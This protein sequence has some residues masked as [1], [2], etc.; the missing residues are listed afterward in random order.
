MSGP[1][2]G[3]YMP[4]CNA[5]SLEGRGPAPYPRLGNLI[6]LFNF[7]VSLKDEPPN[8]IRFAHYSRGAVDCAV[9]L[10]NH[11]PAGRD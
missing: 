1:G 10:A 8:P 6:Y 4:M 11:T 2:P 3:E 7:S 9:R 5:L